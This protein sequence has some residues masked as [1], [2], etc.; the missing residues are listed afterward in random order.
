MSRLCPVIALVIAV[1]LVAPNTRAQTE[2]LTP[3]NSIVLDGIPKIPASLQKVT[4]GFKTVFNDSLIGWD[5][6]KAEPVILRK[7]YSDWTVGRVET[8]AGA[9]NGMVPAGTS[10]I[11]PHPCGQ[12]LLFRVEPWTENYQ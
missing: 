4:D 8:P 11:Y 1:V 9:P 5:P 10:G 7:G 12:Y 2:W 3:P 6:V